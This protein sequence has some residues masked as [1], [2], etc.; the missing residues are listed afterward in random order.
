MTPMA[1]PN[2]NT[3]QSVCPFQLTSYEESDG[4]NKTWCGQYDI[5]ETYS[6]H[7]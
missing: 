2:I 5:M 4:F 6:H 1:S 7:E 3:F